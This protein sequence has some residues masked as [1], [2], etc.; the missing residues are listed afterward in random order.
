MPTMPSLPSRS[1]FKIWPGK[2]GKDGTQTNDERK[3]SLDGP[4]EKEIAGSADTPAQTTEEKE[5]EGR[6]LAKDIKAR[7]I[8]NERLYNAAEAYHS[9]LAK[10]KP[11]PFELQH[12]NALEAS[13]TLDELSNK[14]ATIYPTCPERIREAAKDASQN[15]TGSKDKVLPVE[16]LGVAMAVSAPTY[17]KAGKAEGKEGPCL[18]RN[19][20]YSSHLGLLASVHLALGQAQ[21]KFTENLSSSLLT[22][23]ART[24]ASIDSLR[25]AEKVCDSAREKMEAAEKKRDKARDK[26]ENKRE[27]EDE[28]RQARATY[29]EA[30]ADVET[31]VAILTEAEQE[32]PGSGV[33]IVKEY[34]DL[35]LEWV[36]AQYEILAGTQ[37]SLLQYKEKPAT[38]RT[39][40]SFARPLPATS[41]NG[42]TNTTRG[43][44][45]SSPKVRGS[46]VLP[47]HSKSA[48]VSKP[49]SRPASSRGA[50]SSSVPKVNSDERPTLA[51]TSG[52]S[53][54]FSN[55]EQKTASIRS[56]GESIG[57]LGGR[58]NSVLGRNNSSNDVVK[59]TSVPKQ[60]SGSSNEAKNVG[61][62]TWTSSLL[63]RKRDP[64]AKAYKSM[65]PTEAGGM[66]SAHDRDLSHVREGT[67][68]SWDDSHQ[69]LEV[70]SGVSFGGLD[71]DHGDFRRASEGI[72]GLDLGPQVVHAS[73]EDDVG[74]HPQY[75]AHQHTGGSLAAPN[76]SLSA[77]W[78]GFTSASSEGGDPFGGSTEYDASMPNSPFILQD[79][80]TAL[81]SPREK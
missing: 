34:I 77:Q 70:E 2:G 49:P 4:L 30:S 62:T 53:D 56:R 27:L 47:N 10:K 66:L 24:Q 41:T 3:D 43:R 15:V 35:Q 37:A 42:A 17:S 5:E 32:G 59:L 9:A 78:T 7:R 6:P 44:A 74:S 80:P 12:A 38:N 20:A 39:N 63:S 14:C 16:A 76:S 46:I 67:D 31:R 29:E 75:H 18:S 64:S 11:L 81:A 72:G 23:L 73:H 33:G 61:N 26:G 52:R 69:Q 28:A 60:E 36:K 54:S 51:N 58:L 8:A 50:S 25:S 19:E 45:N 21:S 55:A 1:K 22:R 40:S 68:Q 71:D 65:S 13:M 79:K 57:K 48:S